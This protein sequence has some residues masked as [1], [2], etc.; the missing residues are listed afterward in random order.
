MT[1]SEGAE[2][3]VRPILR[4]ETV[5]SALRQE[6]TDGV[7]APG[8]PLVE[9]DIAARLGVSRTPVRESIQRLAADGLVDSRRRRWIVHV[10]QPEEVSEIYGVRAALESHAARLAALHAD[11]A[12]LERIEAQREVMTKENLIT[13]LERGQANDDFHDLISGASGNPRLLRTIRDQRLFHFNRR[14]AALY[15]EDSLRI[16]SR[17]HGQLIDAVVGRD[18]DSAGE[19]AR[20]HVEYSL[21]LLLDKLF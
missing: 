19:I 20:V 9:D 14:I 10:Y 17:Q 18:A 5:Y 15:D 11:P 7:L 4:S 13:L 3:T 2:G 1:V 12:T 21:Q 6:I 16:T 8:A